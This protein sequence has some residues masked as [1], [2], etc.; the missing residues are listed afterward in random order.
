MTT[1]DEW[2]AQITQDIGPNYR[3]A[4]GAGPLAHDPA[5]LPDCMPSSKEDR[6]IIKDYFSL[7]KKKGEEIRNFF[8]SFISANQTTV[9]TGQNNASTL[10]RHAVEK[11]G[12]YFIKFKLSGLT[13]LA[14][15]AER[16]IKKGTSEILKSGI[17]G[18]FFIAQVELLI[19]MT[20]QE[21][22]QNENAVVKFSYGFANGLLLQLE[23]PEMRDAAIELFKTTIENKWNCISDPEEV[24]RKLKAAKSYKD[25]VKV[26]TGCLYGIEVDIDQAQV[27]FNKALDFIEKNYT[28]PYIQGQAVAFIVTIVLPP[29]IKALQASRF[30]TML[31]NAR[32]A[33]ITKLKN[34][35]NLAGAETIIDDVERGVAGGVAKGGARE[36]WNGFANIFKA[37]A[38]EVA[39][40]ATKIKNHRIAQ[41]AGTSGNYGYLEGNVGSITKNGEMIRSGEP[42]KITQVFEALEV[43]PQQVVGGENSWLRTTDSEYKMLNRLANDLGATKGAKYPNIT[44]ELKIV[45]ERP[46]CPSCQGVIQQFNEM[47]PNVKLILVDG[48][49]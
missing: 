23:I 47:F 40:A 41:N 46:Y 15:C 24:N 13:T 30:F 9:L 29:A 18:A 26:M 5:L 43:N 38:D 11:A 22:C 37:N 2:S 3:S 17:I 49:K 35:R 31:K 48:A 14:A 10:C 39:E 1:I 45:S 27:M 28:N 7:M 16:G 33:L 42:D 21:K 12:T 20:E 44:G 4:L 6:G 36:T 19:C 8:S 32:A 25:V 34:V